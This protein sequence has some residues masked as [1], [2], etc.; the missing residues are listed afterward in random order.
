[1]TQPQP[2]AVPA[3]G[4][5]RVAFV[6]TLADPEF[7]QLVELNA[8]TTVDL[9]CYITAEGFQSTVEEQVTTDDRLCSRATY[10]R[11]GRWSK[12]LTLSY[13]Y[14]PTS[15]PNNLAYST[16]T[17]LT[18]GYIVARWGVPYEQ[19]WADGDLVDVYPVQAGKQVKNAPTANSMLNATQ[20]MFITGEAIDDALVGGS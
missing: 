4:N 6:Q 1:M 16:L 19:P 18:T 5:L 10:E 14:N 13:V 15:A 8:V 7:P 3:D 2:V 11:P 20:R 17:Y 9:S 12:S